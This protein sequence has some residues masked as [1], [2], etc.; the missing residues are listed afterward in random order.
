[1]LNKENKLIIESHHNS[2][3]VSVRVFDAPLNKRDIMKEIERT[4][5]YGSTTILRGALA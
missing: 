3:K 5:R 2:G 4:R 1:M